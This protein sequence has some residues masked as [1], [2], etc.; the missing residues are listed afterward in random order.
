MPDL[1]LVDGG[2]GQVNAALEALA[3]LGV[4]ET[5]LVGLA[6]RE[7]ELYLPQEPRPLRLPRDDA[8]L[9][10]LQEVRDEAHRFAVHRHRGRR[11]KR[12]LRSRLDELPGIGPR[13]RKQLLQRF[14]SLQGVRAASLADLQ[15]ALGPVVG[16][17]VWEEL[18][19]ER[20]DPAAS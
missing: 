1:I 2:R 5:P 15:D 11:S 18:A 9:Q 14:G 19:E 16:G 3:D 13:R 10:L 8:G 4:E 17:E 12:T 7:E 20:R 6:K